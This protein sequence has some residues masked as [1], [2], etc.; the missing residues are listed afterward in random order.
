MD[1]EFCGNEMDYHEII[2]CI[3]CALD[4]R[5]PY[6]AGHLERKFLENPIV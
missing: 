2:D 1:C 4:A 6:T 3:T 5:D